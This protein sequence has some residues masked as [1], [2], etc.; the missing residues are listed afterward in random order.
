MREL[1]AQSLAAI[2]AIA[3]ASEVA[4]IVRQRVGQ[5]F[6]PL[7][8]SV[9]LSVV[10][11]E[12]RPRDYFTWI[13]SRPCKFGLDVAVIVSPRVVSGPKTQGTRLCLFLSKTLPILDHLVPLGS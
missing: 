1:A 6:H 7:R 11:T 2:L 3:P 12:H 4:D 10:A 13:T 9:I 8:S 5:Y